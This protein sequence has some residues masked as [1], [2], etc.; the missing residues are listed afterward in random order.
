MKT[1]TYL[2][3]FSIIVKPIGPLCNLN[4]DYCYYVDKDKNYSYIDKK[5]FI[6]SDEI[7]EMFIK[8]YISIQSKIT[9]NIEFIWQGGEPT[10][11]G[12]DFFKKVVSLQKK[13]NYKNY[14]IHNSIQTNGTLI[15]DKMALFFKAN[16]FL[17]GISIDG[18]K[19]L[20]N[21]YRYDKSSNG[22]FD[23]TLKGLE[24]LKK[25]N[26]EFNTL[27]TVNNINSKYPIE[28]YE[29][30]KSIGSKYMQ[31]IPIVEV[32]E[33]SSITKYSVE[34]Q[35]WGTFMTKIFEHWSKNDIGKIFVQHFDLTLAQYMGLPS[36]MCSHNKYCGRALAMEHD[37][38]IYSCDHFVFDKNYIG[39]IKE[40]LEVIISNKN[41]IEFGYNKFSTLPKECLDCTYLQLCFGG[42]PKN[43]IT[44]RDTGMQNYL[45][46][47][48]KYYYEK[49]YPIYLAMAK[50]LSNKESAATYKKYLNT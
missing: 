36:S 21:K 8:D 17:V 44:Q 15:D 22:S 50:A 33:N 9:K 27:T 29:F 2:Y 6:I 23:K 28:V 7:L 16:N 42:C 45:C 10:L 3:P 32:D 24:L 40:S 13:Y 39:N 19:D 35:L 49:T 14:N 20:H 31:F 34:P 1:T 5:D 11:L 30:L 46:S 4:C 47:G 18:P 38:S 43:R 12:V 37:G 48:F 41:Q 25:Y 26:V